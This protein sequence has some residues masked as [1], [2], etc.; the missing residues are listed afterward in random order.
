M[1]FDMSERKEFPKVE[2]I[3]NDAFSCG[4]KHRLEEAIHEHQLFEC[5]NVGYLL[6]EDEKQIHLADTVWYSYTGEVIVGYCH[7]IPKGCVLK[8]RRLSEKQE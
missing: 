7:I 8:I 3:W 1:L 4:E 5:R 2:V 6:S